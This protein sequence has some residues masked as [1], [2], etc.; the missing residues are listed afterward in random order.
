MKNDGREREAM[1]LTNQLPQWGEIK[2]QGEDKVFHQLV[3]P[4]VAQFWLDNYW[5][6]GERLLRPE[7]IEALTAEMLR[8]TFDTNV[9]YFRVLYGQPYLLNTYHTLKSIIKSGKPQVLIVE[10][11]KAST[12][13]EIEAA[14]ARID[15]GASRKHRD[16]LPM[17]RFSKEFGLNKTQLEALMSAAPILLSGFNRR[18]YS[19]RGGDWKSADIRR[20]FVGD[21]GKVGAT[22]FGLISPATKASAK[23]L[24][25][26]AVV[27]VGLATLNH[28]P[29]KAEAFWLS[30]GEDNGD[31]F[32]PTRQVLNALR[33]ENAR[34]GAAAF[35]LP[36][37]VGR[38]WNA[39]VSGK[40]E[41]KIVKSL[42][43][44][45]ELLETP[46]RLF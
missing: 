24:R 45:F 40:D 4:D 16:V 28:S 14:Y 18:V 35:E 46:Y 20:Q 12:E 21:W 15:R 27:A 37:L 17:E 7:H 1:T 23:L 13:E 42:S 30:V 43:G 26:C 36:R 8:G 19:S 32:S 5:Y 25:R 6:Q 29:K 33:E 22:Y 39:Y 44:A 3:T 34:S 10:V 41:L 38:C 9:A 31:R 2:W 11:R